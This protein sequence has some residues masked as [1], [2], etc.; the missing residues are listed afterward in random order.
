MAEVT[1]SAACNPVRCVGDIQ[2]C[3]EGKAAVKPEILRVLFV[4]LFNVKSLFAA[5]ISFQQ[6]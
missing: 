1:S 6:S 5:F 3:F 2:P 4:L